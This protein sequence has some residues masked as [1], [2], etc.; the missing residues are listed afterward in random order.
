MNPKKLAKKLGGDLRNGWVNIPG[1]GHSERDRSLGI[2]L[3]RRAPGGFVVHSLAGDNRRICRA[4]VE[5]R[6]KDLANRR[7]ISLDDGPPE[8]TTKT[9]SSAFALSLWK[10]AFPIENTPAAVYLGSR[11]CAPPKGKSWPQELR[12]HPACPFGASHSPA[13]VGLMRDVVT[14]E[15]TGIHRTALSDDGGSKRVM[16]GGLPSKMM[17]GRASGAAVHL[18][19]AGKYLGLAEGIETALSAQKIF[20]VP[21]WATLSAGGIGSFPVIYGIRRLFVFADYDDAGL[22]AARKCMDRNAKAGIEVKVQH[23]TEPNTDWND[24][25]LKERI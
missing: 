16:P 22:S 14:G 25:L 23:P 5:A 12:F 4:H 1:P 13:L 6:L 7:H 3:S 17:L 9:N 8:D 18:H 20:K 19:N 24:H 2:R 21:V 11:G 10:E 15:P